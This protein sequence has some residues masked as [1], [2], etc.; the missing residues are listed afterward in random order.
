MFGLSLVELQAF[1]YISYHKTLSISTC[2]KLTTLR[3]TY[4]NYALAALLA[5][6][7]SHVEAGLMIK[8]SVAPGRA[9]GYFGTQTVLG[10]LAGYAAYLVKDFSLIVT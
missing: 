9:I 2:T 4:I 8:G 6:R 10:A 5:F 1:G 3:S 7:I